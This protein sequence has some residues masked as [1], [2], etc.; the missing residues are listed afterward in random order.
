[1]AAL[2]EVSYKLEYSAS[3]GGLWSVVG[4]TSTVQSDDGVTQVVKATAPAG[5]GKRFV[6]LRVTRL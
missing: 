4:T 2:A 3:L 1:M 6:R 5:N